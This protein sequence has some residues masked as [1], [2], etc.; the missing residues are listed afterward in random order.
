MQNTFPT[1]PPQLSIVIPAYNEAKLLPDTLAGLK[2]SLAGARFTTWEVI[3]CD[4]N[5]TDGTGELAAASGA[6]VVHESVNQI[7]RARN[8]GAAAATGEWILFLDADSLPDSELLNSLHTAIADPIVGGG[9]LLAAEPSS[10]WHFRFVMG[11]WNLISRIKKDAAGAFFYCRRDAFESVGGFSSQLFA[12]EEIDLAGRLK[13]WG[14]AKGLGFRIL[15][16]GRIVTSDRKVHLYSTG[17]FLRFFAKSAF[18]RLKNL[19]SRE[20]C[21]IWYDGRR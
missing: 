20:E 10:P 1:T 21:G 8:A 2:Q 9:A 19:R 3:V 16:K 12:A 17:E 4:N 13:K 5:S 14:K 18:S 11:I 15:T 7:S 6:L